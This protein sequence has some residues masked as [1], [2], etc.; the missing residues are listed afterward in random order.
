MIEP[1]ERSLNPGL[2]PVGMAAPA[3]S[4][5]GAIKRQELSV[6]KIIKHTGRRMRDICYYSG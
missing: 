4:P 5:K 2:K 6:I 1:D 3:R